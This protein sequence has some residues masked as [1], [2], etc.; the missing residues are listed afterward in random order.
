MSRYT[1]F[2]D[3]IENNEKK[4]KTIFGVIVVLL[5][6]IFLGGMVLGARSVLD[7]EGTQDPYAVTLTEPEKSPLSKE[8]IL[9]DYVQRKEE[10][11][12]ADTENR[13]KM[14]VYTDLEIPDESVRSE[15]EN[16]FF[17]RE[18]LYVKNKI[19]ESVREYYE[20]YEPGFADDFTEHT[21]PVDFGP[22]DC[23]EITC[24][25]GRTGDDGTL[26]DYGTCF[27][28]FVFNTLPFESAVK[29]N[30]GRSFGMEGSAEVISRFTRDVKD[31]ADVEILSADCSG[32]SITCEYDAETGRLKNEKYN[33]IYSITMSLEFRG[34]FSSL[35]KETVSFEFRCIESHWYTWAGITLNPHEISMEKGDVETIAP[36]RTA[37][38]D[39]E[40]IW[41]SSDPEIA[42]VDEKGYVRGRKISEKPVTITATVTY[43]GNTYSDTCTVYVRKPVDGIETIPE[44]AELKV[45]EQIVLT[46]KVSP[47]KATIKDVLWFTEDES[48]AVVD[49]KGNVTATGVGTVKVYGISRDGWFRSSCNLTVRGNDGEVKDNG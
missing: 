34:D 36:Y 47:E 10:A 32:F 8:E 22:G 17:R 39:L 46:A 44:K 13:V 41:E 37:D 38:E 11:A 12:L 33:R 48:I 29:S 6:L 28:S 7:N 5:I 27:C 15:S 25:R 26:A 1:D 20:N 23:S 19:L 21:I 43:L 42:E 16:E 9:S 18:F 4:K 2:V 24:E 31:F 14:S 45:G 3:S 40:V 49:E 35:G 30:I